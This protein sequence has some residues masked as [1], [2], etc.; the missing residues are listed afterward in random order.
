LRDDLSGQARYRLVVAENA[1]LDLARVNAL[2]NDD[3]PV[4]FRR[5]RNGFVQTLRVNGF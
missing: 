1:D 4:V 2:F 5:R 3:F